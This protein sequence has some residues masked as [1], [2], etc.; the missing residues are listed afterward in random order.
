M[1]D[2]DEDIIVAVRSRVPACHGAEE[3]DPLRMAG[4][5]EP[6]DNLGEDGLASE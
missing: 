2:Q 1:L 3:I 6:P 4:L 5:D